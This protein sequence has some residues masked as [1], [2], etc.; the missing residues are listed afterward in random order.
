VARQVRERAVAA[1]GAVE[2]VVRLVEQQPR[3]VVR[4]RR[5]RD[6]GVV[7]GVGDLL[8][9]RGNSKQERDRRQ[10]PNAHHAAMLSARR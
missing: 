10:A 9:A 8:G 6:A 5:V 1:V 7:R 4:V 2:L 3:P